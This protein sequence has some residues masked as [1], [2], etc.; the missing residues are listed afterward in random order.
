MRV[1]LFQDRFAELVRAGTKRQTIRKAAK[2]KPGDELSLRRWTGKPYRSKQEALRPIEIC[3][4]V[5][6]IRLAIEDYVEAGAGEVARQA[7]IAKADGFSCYA[8]MLE[9]FEK[10]HG[11]PFKGEIVKW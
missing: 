6:P 11:L 3:R 7:L 4:A 9:W 2:C 1:I 5:E 10:T 8:D